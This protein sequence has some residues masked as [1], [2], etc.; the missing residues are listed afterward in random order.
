MFA[1]SVSF[2]IM[3]LL[4]YF[5]VLIC[6]IFL[7]QADLEH[8]APLIAVHLSVGKDQPRLQNILVNSCVSM[9]DD[10]NRTK[11]KKETCV[12]LFAAGLNFKGCLIIQDDGSNFVSD[13]Q[14]S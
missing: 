8:P 10:E 7:L 2:S 5:K 12:T 14:I 3:H 4:T 9:V 11:G 1:I 13:Q 6:T